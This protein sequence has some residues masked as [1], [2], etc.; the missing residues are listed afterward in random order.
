MKRKSR[1][2]TESDRCYVPLNFAGQPGLFQNGVLALLKSEPLVPLSG[3]PAVSQLYPSAHAQADLVRSHWWHK[4]CCWLT[5]IL[6]EHPLESKELLSFV[7]LLCFIFLNQV[8]IVM[9]SLLWGQKY[10]QQGQLRKYLVLIVKTRRY[11]INSYS[12]SL[13]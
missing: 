3:F 8:L 7:F 13:N 12:T 11:F 10:Q 9:L 1:W 5:G 4:V 6:Q 2:C